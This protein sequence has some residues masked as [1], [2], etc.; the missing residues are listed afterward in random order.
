MA[1]DVKREPEQ[2]IDWKETE[3]LVTQLRAKLAETEPPATSEP[4]AAKPTVSAPPKK[5]K[6]SSAAAPKAAPVKAE[7]TKA[8]PVAAEQPV[9]PDEPAVAEVPAAEAEPDASAS[10]ADPKT[11]PLPTYRRALPTR[12]RTAMF[13]ATRGQELTVE[14]RAST[15]SAGKLTGKKSAGSVKPRTDKELA[16]EMTVEDLM[17]DLFGDGSLGWTP[18]E[19]ADQPHEQ[20]AKTPPVPEE[21]A[22]EAPASKPEAPA[23]K[24]EA[25]AVL[26]KKEVRKRAKEG[27]PKFDTITREEDGQMALVLPETGKPLALP[28]RDRGVHAR[29]EETPPSGRDEEQIDLFSAVDAAATEQL[30]KTDLKRSV[31]ASEEEF[32][33][34]LELDY[35][36]EL[37]KAIG[38]EK[39]RAYHEE[40]VN[41]QPVTKHRRRAGERREYETQGQDTVLRKTYTKQKSEHVVRLA[42]SVVMTLLIM[43]YEQSGWMKELF[44][45]FLDGTKYPVTYILI[46]IQL[47][48]I[49]AFFSY[50]RLLEGFLRI[51]SFSP[52]DYSLCSMMLIATFVYH[53]VLIF[54]PNTGVAPRLYLSPAAMSLTLLALA[55]LLDWYRESL[56]FQ[57]VSSRKQKYALIPRVSVGGRQGNARLSL[58]DDESAGTVWYVR[59]VGFVRNYFANTEKHVDHGRTLGVQL[60][61]I[62]SVGVAFGLYALAGGATLPQML[63]TVFVTFLLC[64]P[65]TSLLVTSLPMFFAAC[66]RLGKK[67]AII[68]ESPVY[69]SEGTTTLVIPD[70]EVFGAM[71]HER[72]EVQNEAEYDRVTVLTRA[73]LEKLQSPLCDSVNVE[74]DRR[75]SPSKVELCRIEED[76]VHATV[77]QDDRVTVMHMGSLSYMKSRGIEELP[78]LGSE[79][80][81]GG[82][83]LICVAVNGRSVAFFLARYRLNDDMSA[84][85]REME[86]EGVRVM[87]RTK[88]PGIRDDLFAGLLPDRRDPVLVMK[89]TAREMD[90]RTDRVDATV[91]AL[92]SCR[93]AARTFV[94]CRRSRRA[95]HFGKI[96][97]V[98]SVTVGGLIAALLTFLGGSVQLASA[99]VS[100][101]LL[102]WSALHAATSFLFLRKT[103]N[104]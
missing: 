49:V 35:E 75:I 86:A 7:P 64:V 63:Q 68:G 78:N 74:R 104:E 27:K 73:L 25:P 42:L 39:I 31:E 5:K 57:V 70:S 66:L 96:F 22:P 65:V 92:G 32:R 6:K 10:A 17:Q 30:Y 90:L 38:F 56:A 72:F 76:G 77:T 84:L 100:L 62:L 23:P 41:G 83:R 14:R 103:E 55:D 69:D 88:D 101:Y 13:A 58:S 47:L 79:A 50:R 61:L 3:W 37:G 80:E 53:V 36:D 97:Q 12:Q 54:L 67:G 2:D 8:E 11:E 18:A 60:L 40:G 34:L 82:K 51:L 43:I 4:A 45:G 59:P 9:I 16:A 21:K 52:I 24:A 46:G 98:L 29:R 99:L 28:A 89:P 85:L 102:F 91:V 33:L 87:I 44:G 26:S 94:T 20:A 93:E 19:R 15:R 1:K 95:A 48:V 71:H 81:Q